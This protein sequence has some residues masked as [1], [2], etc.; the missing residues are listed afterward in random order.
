LTQRPPGAKNRTNSTHSVFGQVSAALSGIRPWIPEARFTNGVVRIPAATFRIPNATWSST[1]GFEARA[2]WEEQGIGARMALSHRSNRIERLVIDAEDGTF[3][4]TFRFPFGTQTRVEGVGIWLSNRVSLNAVFG[5]VGWL[6]EV[7][8]I[9]APSFT[10]P[11]S[12][13]KLPGYQD[14]QGAFSVSW[15]D[16]RFQL[17]LRAQAENQVAQTNLPPLELAVLAAGT[18]NGVTIHKATVSS[19]FL[20][21]Q[22][23]HVLEF[24]LAGELLSGPARLSLMADLDS[25]SW[26]DAQGQIAGVATLIPQVGNYPRVQMVLNGTN[27]TAA[28][29]ELRNV[30]I[31]AALDYPNLSLESARGDFRDGTIL[32][33]RG[34][35]DLTQ[36]SIR[37]GELS[38]DA[39]ALPAWIP[40]PY[41]S[42]P[43]AITARGS[44]SF[45]NLEHSGSF[46]L[47]GVAGPQFKPLDLS[48]DWSG[49]QFD[50]AQLRLSATGRDSQVH[51]ETSLSLQDH[52]VRLG[53][54]KFAFLK[55]DEPSLQLQHPAEIVV[56]RSGP[57]GPGISVTGLEL[58]GSSGNVKLSS[59]LRTASFG[60]IDLLM[61]DFDPAFLGAFVPREI[62]E[63]HVSHLRFAGSWSNGPITQ[64]LELNLTIPSA[65]VAASL[66][67]RG[68]ASGT[69][70]SNALITRAGAPLVSAH[71]F[72]PLSLR[73]KFGWD[74]ITFLTNAPVAFSL[75]VQPDGYL[76]DE[77]GRRTGLVVRHPRVDAELQGD[78]K[79]LQGL[80]RV[81]M[82]GIKFARTNQA[83]PE[84]Q[85]VRLVARIDRQSARIE[86][87]DFQ[88][89]GETLRAEAQVPLG[90]DYWVLRREFRLPDWRKASAR[91]VGE[92]IAVAAFEP[93]FPT[94]LSPQGELKLDLQLLPGVRLAGEL[95]INDARTRPIATVGAIRDIRVS[96]I[97]T[98]QFLR[99]DQATA[100]IGGSQVSIAGTAD[101]AQTSWWAEGVPNFELVV[102]GTNIPLSRTSASII[103]ADLDLAVNKTNGAA[104]FVSGVARLRESIFMTDLTSL[105]PGGAATPERRPPYF[106]VRQPPFSNWRLGV[107]VEGPKFLSVRSTLFYGQVTANLELTGTLKDP[108][109]LGDL[110]IDSGTVKLPFADLGVSQGFISLGSQDPYR[111]RI[112]VTA[113]S[114]QYGYD[115]RV[116]VSGT[117][118]A[119][120]LQ[121]SSTPPLGSEEIL[122]MVT[123]GEMPRHQQSFSMRQRGQ[124]FAQFLGK[125]LL[126]KLGFADSGEQRLTIKSGEEL[127]E[128]GRPTYGIDYK[129]SDRW[130]LVGEYDRFNAFN[131]GFKW[132]IY[133]K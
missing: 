42:G 94:L 105:V 51:I 107:K 54:K 99:L 84:V 14:V 70:I 56:A 11:A 73:P 39:K 109:A 59:V 40:A 74:A 32:F 95:Q 52:L 77:I 89:Q 72:L 123:A 63:L 91:I 133:S 33:A 67:I 16:G 65:T 82:D 10:V 36:R 114:R 49:R 61:A 121:F 130:A 34:E 35:I 108:L 120:M 26:L 5:P 124:T 24:N 93:L 30:K 79:T 100:V 68:D 23:S 7:A 76:W 19:P 125:D 115:I 21:A 2:L 122:L 80:V 78:W 66:Q 48:G 17:D 81:N 6:P 4:S 118:D 127:S 55:K 131:A 41:T 110:K 117:V 8:Q 28:K 3:Q 103:R 113:G 1:Q 86:Q 119:P 47:R 20:S 9:A 129:L 60:S 98:N 58:S 83:L 64:N 90:N 88:V 45:T 75:Q 128:L 116:D 102:R 31:A 50:L 15:A 112:S 37:N 126:T 25:Q 71:G 96:A 43:V 132:R 85:N 22:L 57:G 44:G 13:L 101:F 62:P 104:P 18:T 111:P 106:S 87:F 27:L 53:L 92:H 29:V 38:I 97:F 46:T 12:V 69:A